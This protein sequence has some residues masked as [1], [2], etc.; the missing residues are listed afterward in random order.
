MRSRNADR[1]DLDADAVDYNERVADE[2][3]IIRRGYAACLRAL[4]EDLIRTARPDDLPITDLGA[5]TGTLLRTLPPDRPAVAVDRSRA[6]LERAAA[7]LTGRPVT[8]VHEDLLAYV[9]ESDHPLGHV[10]STFAL[11]C[12]FSDEKT[13]LL[14]AVG[15]RLHPGALLAIGDLGFADTTARERFLGRLDAAP[16]RSATTAQEHYWDWSSAESTL[17]ALG[18]RV[19]RRTHG[20][21]IGSLVAVRDPKLP[22]SR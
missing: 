9:T 22:S 16:H 14:E 10:V 21:L 19:R 1:Y 6:M 20:P 5:G 12:L 13:A 4:S 8:F 2:E 11:H 15:R 3:V 7:A 17:Q 18:F